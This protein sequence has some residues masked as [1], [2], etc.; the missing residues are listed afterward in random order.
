MF[1]FSKSKTYRAASGEQAGDGRGLRLL[2][3]QKV[4]K[5]ELYKRISH[6]CC[7]YRRFLSLTSVQRSLLL[8]GGEGG[9]VVKG[10]DVLA[11]QS[12][13]VPL[14][15]KKK[16]PNV[17]V[18]LHVAA[19]RPRGFKTVQTQSHDRAMPYPNNR[20]LMMRI[21]GI[22]RRLVMIIRINSNSNVSS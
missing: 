17:L 1:D 21:I 10:T 18:R 3:S 2:E 19:S 16:S 9:G 7:K 5:P 14:G 22:I 12:T 6:L 20:V 13:A 8:W 15:R 11:Q 4:S